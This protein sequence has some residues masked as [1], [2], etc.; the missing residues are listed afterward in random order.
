MPPLGEASDCERDIERIVHIPSSRWSVR[1]GQ[2]LPGPR[3][4]SIR[5]TIYI[6]IYGYIAIHIYVTNVRR[7]VP[8]QMGARPIPLS[9]ESFLRRSQW[10]T[11]SRVSVARSVR[12]QQ[13]SKCGCGCADISGQASRTSAFFVPVDRSRGSNPDQRTRLDEGCR[14][15]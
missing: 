12:I 6:Y 5:S 10:A 7:S 13:P 14:R 15:R 4:A 2:H 8:C 9:S 1:E 11:T 3:P